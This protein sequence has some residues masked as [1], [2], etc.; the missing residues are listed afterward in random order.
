MIFDKLSNAPIYYDI[1]DRIA[2]ALKWLVET[3][4]D[5]VPDGRHEIDGDDIFVNA[6]TADTKLLVNNVE[7][8]AKHIDIQ[9]IHKGK[10]YIGFMPAEFHGKEVKSN[11]ESDAYHFEGNPDL[12]TAY[13]GYFMLLFPHDAHKPR[14]AIGNPAKT[15]KFV[16]KVKWP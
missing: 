13:E 5:E 9:Y 2:R 7:T 6:S 11:P 12:I 14:I 4:L 3:N 16:V 8:H 10:E 15:R 1:N